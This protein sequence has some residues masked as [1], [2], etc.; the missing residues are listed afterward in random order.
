MPPAPTITVAVR[1]GEPLWRAFGRHRIAV[2]LPAPAALADL[3]AALAATYPDFR[4]RY[5]GDDLGHRHPYR[6]FVNH[7]QISD[8][9]MARQPLNDGDLVH[10]VIP[11]S[12]GRG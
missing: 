10:I 6:L 4:S 5:Q 7:R 9:E 11:V 2:D 1:A 12:G 8:E 3:L